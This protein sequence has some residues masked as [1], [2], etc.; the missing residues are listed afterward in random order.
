MHAV[1]IEAVGKPDVLEWKERPEPKPGPGQVAI[2]VALT[3]VNFADVQQRRGTGAGVTKTP[4][5]TGLDCMGTIRALGEGVRDLRVGQ[6]VSASPD[7]G[8]YAEVVLARDVLTFPVDGAISDEAAAS[9]TVLV[10]AYN[11]LNMVARLQSGESVLI[12]SAAGGV[13]SV[14]VQMAKRLGAGPIFATAGGEKKLQIARE[15][16]ADVAIDYTKDD[17]A[18]AILDATKG[19]GVDVILDAVGGDV[20]A[21]GL[22]ALANFG[23]YCVYGQS[24]GSP[25]SLTTDNL[26]RSNRAVLGYSS[27][28][29]RRNRPENIRPGMEAALKMVADGK[30]KILSG[31]RFPLREAAKAHQLVESR[32]STGRIFLTVT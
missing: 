8:S 9:P 11:L 5:I 25:G 6:R 15:C 30:V 10:T 18:K 22:P 13:G 19:K 4:F 16:G 14:A 29:Y 2:D 26:H 32:T 3:S 20:F 17:F 21:K 1:V 28:H 31:G 12:H 24:S 23:R 7:G 27:G